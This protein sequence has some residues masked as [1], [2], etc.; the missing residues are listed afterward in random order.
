MTINACMLILVTGFLCV[1][2]VM[3]Q[4]P[5]NTTEIPT[6]PVQSL[7]VQQENSTSPAQ[8]VQGELL[9]KF[10]PEAYPNMNALTAT[11]M[12]RHAA[13]GA[14]IIPDFQ[15]TPGWQHIRLPSMMTMEDGI[16]YYTSI[17]TVQYVEVNAIY[18]IA[19]TSSANETADFPPAVNIS[20]T[21]DLFV[22][23]NTTAFQAPA[24]LQSYANITNAAINATLV[25]DYS[26][27]GMYGLQLVELAGNMTIEE[28]ITY[29]NTT[30]N[31]TYAEPNVQY[32]A[33]TTQT[34]T[35]NTTPG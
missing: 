11:S 30:P 13:I 12:L 33:I 34:N 10:N 15:G 5:M 31:V 27:F 2:A 4:I 25:T 7:N 29:Y 16:A 9:V 24:E 21:G 6:Q 28:G 17:P 19:N 14:Q 3:A 8:F 32:Q 20:D 26:P 23:Y 1:A 22:Q 35:T 18:S